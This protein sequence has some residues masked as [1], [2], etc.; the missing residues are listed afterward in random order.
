M[1]RNAL[2]WIAAL[3]LAVAG[4]ASVR[5]P[6]PG[7]RF[8]LVRHAEKADDDPRDPSLSSAGVARAEALARRLHRDDVAAVYATEYRRTRQTAQPVARD[9][10]V[11]ITPYDAQSAAASFAAQLRERHAHGTVLVVGHSNT[12]P[13]LAAALC[14]CAIAPT[15]ETEF[16]RRITVD[17][18][19]DGRVTVDDRRE[20]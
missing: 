20:P 9:H 14:S 2:R 3:A 11:A 6:A 10:G 12:I 16:G 5:A 7:V 18:L 1:H 15:A 19:P 17:V 4:C 8:V 13:A